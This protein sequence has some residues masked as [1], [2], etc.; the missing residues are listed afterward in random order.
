[1]F[2]REPTCNWELT[3]HDRLN[4]ETI[5]SVECFE[6]S[7]AARD[8]NERSGTTTRGQAQQR[9]VRHN[10][11]RSGT[12]TRGQGQQRE[13]SESSNGQSHDLRGS[14]SLAFALRSAP[15]FINSR[16]TASRSLFA[17]WW[18]A[19]QPDSSV[20]LMLALSFT[21]ISITFTCPFLAARCSAV[22]PVQ[23]AALTSAPLSN[24]ARTLLSWPF[25]ADMWSGIFHPSS[26]WWI[27]LV[28]WCIVS[29]IFDDLIT[30]S[31][32]DGLV[33][34]SVFGAV[35]LNWSWLH[36][37]AKPE[38]YSKNQK[39]FVLKSGMSKT[40]FEWEIQQ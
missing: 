13:V 35:L 25:S 4:R 3:A 20:A 5:I 32:Q 18:S 28:V 31:L 23:L 8:N 9:E 38:I 22:R 10:N 27:V 40:R 29:A 1:M 26:F 21:S 6:P 7:Y 2:S 36:D 14:L 37:S 12:T 24:N 39:R 15:R 16:R 30:T 17:A 11:E 33:A 34:A 19:V